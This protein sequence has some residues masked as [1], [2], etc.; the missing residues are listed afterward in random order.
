MFFTWVRVLT[1]WP[2]E[3]TCV[4]I[5]HGM[6]VSFGELMRL[7]LPAVKF[8]NTFRAKDQAIHYSLLLF[9]Y[10]NKKP[11]LLN[12][13]CLYLPAAG[14]ARHAGDLHIQDRR[15]PA[16][17]PRSGFF[18]PRADSSGVLA[19]VPKAGNAFGYLRG[20][21]NVRVVTN[22]RLRLDKQTDK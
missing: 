4:Q 22:F 13:S 21:D 17:F 18:G 20:R 1:L 8:P 16:P 15:R 3:S 19:L 12:I 5:N 2:Q 6:F 10:R 9:S 7:L 11:T 14:R